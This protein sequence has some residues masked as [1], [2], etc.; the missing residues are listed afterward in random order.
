MPDQLRVTSITNKGLHGLSSLISIPRLRSQCQR[1]PG[2]ELPS[3]HQF[4]VRVC[5]FTQRPE[6]H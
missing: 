1:P 4:K 2:L 3:A 6:L 5:R